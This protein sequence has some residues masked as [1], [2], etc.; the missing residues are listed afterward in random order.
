MTTIS[1]RAA[2]RA[3]TPATAVS[4]IRQGADEKQDQYNKQNGAEL[5]AS[6]HVRSLSSDAPKTCC[7][8]FCSRNCDRAV[9]AVG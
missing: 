9:I 2:G 8:E 3:V 4:P 1:P 7:R 6:F 5:G